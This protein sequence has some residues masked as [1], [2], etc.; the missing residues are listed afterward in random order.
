MFLTVAGINKGAVKCMNS[1]EDFHD[2]FIFDKDHESVKK[3]EHVYLTD[4]KPVVWP[5]G[6]KSDF[7]YGINMRPTGYKL[8]KPDVYKEAIQVMESGKIIFSEYFLSKA[9]GYFRV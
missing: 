1:I 8:S 7:K 3:L 9:R 2:G 5:D 4:M 6:Y